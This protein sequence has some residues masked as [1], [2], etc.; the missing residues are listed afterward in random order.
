MAISIKVIASNQLTSVVA[1]DLFAPVISGK[2]QIIKTMRFANPSTTATVTMNLY[3][4]RSSGLARQIAPKNLTI[5]PGNIY[6]DE[7]EITLEAGD[8]VRGSVSGGALDYVI[9]GI[10]RDV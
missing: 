5:P 3:F 7:T 8:R 6:V 4:S 1:T 2:T 10:E 9:S